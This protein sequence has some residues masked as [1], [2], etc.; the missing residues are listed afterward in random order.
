M[1][2]K[3]VCFV[4]FFLLG[5]IPLKTYGAPLLLVENGQAKTKIF[6][7][8]DAPRAAKDLA[9]NVQ[10]MS[11]DKMQ[12]QQT[13][14]KNEIPKNTPAIVVGSLTVKTGLN[15][16]PKTRSGDGYRV[17]RR[18]NLLL[19]AGE[20]P[21]S[22]FYATSHFLESLGCRWFFGNPLGTVIPNK[23]TIAVEKLDVAEKPDFISRRVWGPNWHGPKP[24]HRHNRVGG[25]SMSAGHDWGHVPPKKYAEEHPE[26][27]TLRGGKRRPGNWLCTSNKDVQRIFADSIIKNVKGKGTTSVSIS[28]PDGR[29]YCQ[30]EKCRAL[31]DPD[32]REPSSGHVVITDR[33]MRFFNAVAKPVRKAN[34]DAILNFYAYADYSRPSKHVK[35]APDNLCVWVAPIRYCRFHSLLSPICEDRQRLR[36]EL[37]TWMSVVSKMGWREYNYNLAEAT[38]PFSK[39][40]LWAKDIP[41]LHRIGCIGVN[42][43]SLYLWHIYGPHTYLIPRLLWD[44]E[45]DVDAIMD[46]FYTKFCGGAAPHVK[47]YWERIDKAYQTTDTHVGSF[48]G[49][50][51]IWTPELVKACQADL[52]AAAKVAKRDITRKRVEMFQMG[53]DNVKYFRDLREATNRCDFHKAKEIYDA[54]LAHMDAVN[55]KKIHYIG[56]YRR[57]YVPRF[58]G[59]VVKQG[60]E[61]TTGNNKLL[62]RL[63]DTWLFRYDPDDKGEKKG[64]HT[65]GADKKGW[66]EVRTYSATLSEQDVEEQLTWMWY[67][68][69]IQ[70]PKPPGNKRLML[71]VGEVD[72][73]PTKVF[74]NGKLVGETR[75]KRRPFEMEVTDRLQ[76]GKNTIALKIDHHNISELHLGGL[77]KPCMI[78]SAPK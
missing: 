21:R 61:C 62:V 46:D 76:K 78:Y 49:I 25:L 66:K 63:P 4:A 44:A 37:D 67:R 47:A 56:E 29:G 9:A 2:N 35:T 6:H 60:Y 75:A 36:K 31:D 22:T 43:E 13:A 55:K 11:G 24:W 8:G 38:V 34:P 33:Y 19:M 65:P 10:K 1:K 64:W 72:G 32:Y 27:Y 70:A 40:S 16:P 77:I 45:A 41:Y 5:M 51:E 58:L 26:Y 54:W 12:I 50:H 17:L 59:K 30:C 52:K 42:I 3:M 57:G 53:L 14:D 73:R 48:Y 28:P 23:K 15:A 68:T 20:T 74:L 71:W 18:G 39:I 69:E 7:A